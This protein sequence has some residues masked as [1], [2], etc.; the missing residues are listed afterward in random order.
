MEQALAKLRSLGPLV[1]FEVTATLLAI[2]MILRAMSKAGTV[3]HG[4]VFFTEPSSEYVGMEHFLPP[5]DSN[6]DPLFLDDGELTPNNL[7]LNHK[8]WAVY[9]DAASFD[10]SL[11]L[12]ATTAS[13]TARANIQEKANALLTRHPSAVAIVVAGGFIMW[14]TSEPDLGREGMLSLPKRWQSWYPYEGRARNFSKI[15][16]DIDFIYSKRPIFVFGYSQM[17][18]GISYRSS[19]RVPTHFVLL[20]GKNMSMCRLVQAAGRANGDQAAV[21]RKNGF[22]QVTILT[23]AHDYDIIIH[24]PDFLHRIRT[25]MEHDC[26]SLE[27]ALK[28]QH[29]GC[30]KFTGHDLGQKKLH[31]Q[32]YLLK[33]NHTVPNPGELPGAENEDYVITKGQ[34]QKRAILELLVERGI[35]CEGTALNSTEVREGLQQ[36]AEFFNSFCSAEDVPASEMELAKITALLNSLSNK[37]PHR[38]AVV[39]KESSSRR[40][41]FFYDP[42]VHA[43]ISVRPRRSRACSF[44]SPAE[45]QEKEDDPAVPVGAVVEG[46]AAAAAELDF[47]HQQ[48]QHRALQASFDDQNG[49]SEGAGPSNGSAD[50]DCV[51]CEGR[52]AAQPFPWDALKELCL[53]AVPA[54]KEDLEKV[55]KK[56]QPSEKVNHAGQRVLAYMQSL[57]HI[58]KAT[59]T[60]PN[61]KRRLRD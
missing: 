11:C 61:G 15:L 31:L 24:Y 55:L 12:D 1:Q 9:N 39:V 56:L 10:R 2:F 36:D 45:A 59:E 6:G 52:I 25:H 5:V 8:V 28:D 48:L 47:L 42:A 18:R 54:C 21:L 35:D 22:E 50:H 46:D 19:R 58:V 23:K 17:M 37:P 60:K 13:V 51:S 49:S 7:Y 29:P 57:S 32:K 40:P 38:E 34:S 26:I 27:E 41:R 14:R 53:D 3:T 44:N 30:F 16:E 4:D 33:L 20:Y 43:A